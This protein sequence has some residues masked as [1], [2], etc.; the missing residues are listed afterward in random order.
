MSNKNQGTHQS[1]R[2]KQTIMSYLDQGLTDRTE[3]YNRVVDDLGVPRPTV[4]RVA[5]NL[6]TELVEKIQS[7][8]TDITN[9]ENK[10]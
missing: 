6:K 5:H 10:N 2:I 8:E 3:I 9:S 1:I 7:L 4:R